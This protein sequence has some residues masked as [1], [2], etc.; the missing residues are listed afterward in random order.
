MP[1]SRDRLNEAFVQYPVWKQWRIFERFGGMPDLTAMLK[2]PV[3]GTIFS[4][5][6]F[7][8]RRSVFGEQ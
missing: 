3:S 1:R 7:G 4:D 6:K 2:T 5:C 8:W